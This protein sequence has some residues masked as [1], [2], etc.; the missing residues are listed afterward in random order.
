MVKDRGPTRQIERRFVS[1]NE[2]SGSVRRKEAGVE[3]L[4]RDA[5]QRDIGAVAQMQNRVAAAVRRRTCHYRVLVIGAPVQ[6][7]AVADRLV[8]VEYGVVAG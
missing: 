2:S 3:L 4:D 1:E 5:D 6:G 8:E 7:N